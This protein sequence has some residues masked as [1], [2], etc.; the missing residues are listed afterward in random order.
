MESFDLLIH[1]DTNDAAEYYETLALG[2][3]ALNESQNLKECL[4]GAFM[5]LDMLMQ[6]AGFAH[7]ESTSQPSLKNMLLLLDRIEF[8]IEKQLS[9]KS[10]MIEILERLKLRQVAV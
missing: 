9:T 3:R 10:S 1:E 2:L 8:T 4:R 7:P 6:A 5:T